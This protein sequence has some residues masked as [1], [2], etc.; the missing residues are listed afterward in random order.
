MRQPRLLDVTRDRICVRHFSYETETVY[1]PYA[2]PVAQFHSVCHPCE[3]SGPE[4]MGLLSYLAV[5]H[6][7]FPQRR[8][9]RR[10]QR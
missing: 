6:R 9:P 10:C 4:S 8:I 3:R 2:Y 7:V 1:L 5:A